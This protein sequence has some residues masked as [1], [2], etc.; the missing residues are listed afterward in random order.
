M[1][2][3]GG[4]RLERPHR[5]IS[6]R[7]WEVF[8]AACH[9]RSQGVRRAPLPP[10]PLGLRRLSPLP[11]RQ[12]PWSRKQGDDRLSKSNAQEVYELMSTAAQYTDAATQ[13]TVDF[14]WFY[15]GK[16]RSGL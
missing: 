3:P 15:Y 2:E 13:Y 4:I 9:D 6:S 11:W 16:K 8:P 7:K 12:R 5:A 1:D 10:T 14:Y